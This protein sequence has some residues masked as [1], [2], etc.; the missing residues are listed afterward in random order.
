[1]RLRRHLY[2]KVNSRKQ[3]GMFHERDRSCIVGWTVGVPSRVLCSPAAY[4]ILPLLCCSSMLPSCIHATRSKVVPR[5]YCL[6]L[7]AVSH[8]QLGRSKSA[9]IFW[10]RETDICLNGIA[11]TLR[12]RVPHAVNLGGIR[13]GTGRG[14]FC[15]WGIGSQI[16]SCSWRVSS[17]PIIPFGM[18]PLP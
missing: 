9:M 11:P 16:P 4:A 18:Q 13:R 2:N 14:S 10:L 3:P 5:E 15:L 6:P 17:S 7:L 12:W 1:M 8:S